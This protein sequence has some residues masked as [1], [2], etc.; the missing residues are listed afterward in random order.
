MENEIELKN[1]FTETYIILN[2]LKL[3]NKIPSE[4]KK[5]MKENLNNNYNFRFN[6]NVPLFNQVDNQITRNL[7][8]YIYI[9]YINN[10]SKTIEF[11]KN[12]I[13]DIFN[14]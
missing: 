1:A 11:L 2:E 13:E 9:N 5:L 3:F 12:E 14:N 7:L 8:T 6:I 4:L 10:D